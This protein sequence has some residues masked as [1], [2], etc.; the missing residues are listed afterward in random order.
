MSGFLESS[1]IFLDEEIDVNDFLHIA[2]VLKE[3]M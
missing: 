1:K 2:F 3:I